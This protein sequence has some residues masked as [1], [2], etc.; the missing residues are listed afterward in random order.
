MVAEYD[1]IATAEF[2]KELRVQEERV[3]KEIPALR[4]SEGFR[5]ARAL[6]IALIIDCTASMSLWIDAAKI[7]LCKVIEQIKTNVVKG[8]SNLS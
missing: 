8:S 4:A 2:L 3:R 6:D 5:A 7:E 1:E